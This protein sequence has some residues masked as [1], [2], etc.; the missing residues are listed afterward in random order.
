MN[1]CI[2]NTDSP[3]VFNS[4]TWGLKKIQTFSLGNT[5]FLTWTHHIFQILDYNLMTQQY[6]WFSHVS[7]HDVP[8][9]QIYMSEKILAEWM[10]TKTV[11]CFS[12]NTIWFQKHN[13]MFFGAFKDMFFRKRTTGRFFKNVHFVFGVGTKF[14]DELSH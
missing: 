3:C 8:C 9:V 12:N 7:E 1:K 2:V 14:W 13:F 11:G 5:I 6:H 4:E 10:M